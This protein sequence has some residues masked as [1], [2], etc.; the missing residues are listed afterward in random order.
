MSLRSERALRRAIAL[1]KSISTSDGDEERAI[2]VAIASLD[3]DIAE[4]LAEREAFLAEQ[5]AI[6]PPTAAQV[7]EIASLAKELDRMTA[8]AKQAKSII[9]AATKIFEAWSDRPRNP[10]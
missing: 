3:A 5:T 7:D 4:V 2:T 1:L 8:N 9:N 10:A 6:A